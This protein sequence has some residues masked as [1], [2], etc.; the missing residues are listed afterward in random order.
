MANPGKSRFIGDGARWRALAARDAAAD[1]AFVYGVKTTGVFCRPGCPSR[2][3]KRANVVF[4][5]DAQAALRGGYRAC[6]RCRPDA[7]SPQNRQ[8]GLIAAACQTIAAAETPPTLD[9]LARQ[10]GLSAAHFH[11]VFKGL[12]GVTPKQYAET[13]RTR[14]FREALATEA[15]VTEAIFDAGYG[16]S[17]RAY[18]GAAG[19]L[20]MTPSQYR[21]GAT[22]LEIRY[23]TAPCFLGRVL[24]GA[25][26]AG[27]CAIELGDSAG[28]LLGQLAGRFPGARLR[29]AAP[30]FAE[31]V[32][33]VAAFIDDPAR[34]LDVALDIRGTAF[35]QRVWAALRGIGPGQ[36]ASYA[37]IAQRIGQPDGARAVAGACAANRLAVAVPCH[38]VVRKDG[39][40]SGYRWGKPRKQALLAREAANSRDRENI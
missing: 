2:Q 7:G 19:R 15:S 10:A 20:G 24:V 23:A 6:K 12:L 21:N 11:K 14:R 25:T 8:A 4:F 18:D 22:G 33:R 29:R 34:G 30:G 9:S 35:Q 27:I 32:A 38:R 1:G 5:A 36:T 13:A 31:T 26:G 37:D 16:S 3:A 17:S 40:V 28:A 39:A